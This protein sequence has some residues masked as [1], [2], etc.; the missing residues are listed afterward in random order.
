MPSALF[1]GL[2]VLLS[3]GKTKRGMIWS[4]CRSPP[5]Y[6]W[7]GHTKYPITIITMDV[8]ISCLL[9]YSVEEEIKWG[10]T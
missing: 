4:R 5:T 7:S 3:E 8:A 6:Y 10:L 1:E 9:K 2:F